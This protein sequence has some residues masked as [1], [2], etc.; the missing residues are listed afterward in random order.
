MKHCTFLQKNKKH[1]KTINLKERKNKKKRIN[2]KKC[3]IVQIRKKVINKTF[4]FK[5]PKN[6]SLMDNTVACTDF[7]SDI[8]TNWANGKHKKDSLFIDFEEVTNFDFPAIILLKSIIQE[9][10]DLNI[11]VK[12]NLP[13]NDECCKSLKEA[14]FRNNMYDNKGNKIKDESKSIELKIE[15]GSGR[16]TNEQLASISSLLKN[17]S[18]HLWKEIVPLTKISDV[19][20]EICG[21][22][23]EWAKAYKDFWM[24][25]LEFK[26]KKV[27]FV[28]VDLGLGIL[29]TIYRK[30]IK[31][32]GDIVKKDNEVLYR[33]FDGKYGSSTQEI[34][35]NHG[36]PYIKSLSEDGS[37]KNLCV[38]TNNVI[39]N[40]EDK[41]KSVTF[42]DTKDAFRGTLYTWEI[43]AN[44]QK[45]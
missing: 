6:F 38:L 41:N 34:N 32:I 22:S 16:L 40:F 5:C 25:G 29:N 39:I 17:T 31:Q 42:A 9:F 35:R 43:D 21:N 20:K 7:I 13:K 23:I 33:A 1:I 4:M 30:P 18:L 27:R 44:C 14:G 12:G 8:R 36:L 15:M 37:V 11:L 2:K 10:T 3:S 24:I 26:E 45:F 28:A 19:I